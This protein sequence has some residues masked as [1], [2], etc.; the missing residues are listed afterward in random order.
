MFLPECCTKCAPKSKVYRTHP[1]SPLKLSVP[2]KTSAP[3]A[4]CILAQVPNNPLAV[5][6]YRWTRSIIRAAPSR[7]SSNFLP[8]VNDGAGSLLWEY[9]LCISRGACSCRCLGERKAAVRPSKDDGAWF[10]SAPLGTCRHERRVAAGPLRGMRGATAKEKKR[11]LDLK[12]QDERNHSR[13]TVLEMHRSVRFHVKV[14]DSSVISERR[15]LLCTYLVQIT[16]CNKT[17]K[18]AV[19]HF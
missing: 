3:H 10:A 14:G 7:R 11:E 16:Q 15:P 5:E 17:R 6:L 18:S 8:T 1:G 9:N 13:T 2:K 12:A 4:P 19:L